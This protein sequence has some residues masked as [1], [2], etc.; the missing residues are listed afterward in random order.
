MMLTALVP[1][2]G[3]HTNGR[4]R[5]RLTRGRGHRNGRRLAN[6]CLTIFLLSLTFM[7][8]V[9]VALICTRPSSHPKVR[10]YFQNRC[11]T[12]TVGGK[13]WNSWSSRPLAE[14]CCDRSKRFRPRVLTAFLDRCLTGVKQSPWPNLTPEFAARSAADTSVGSVLRQFV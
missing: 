1:A 2:A 3:T 6:A 8:D 4:A 12:S 11:V 5:R 14:Y 9:I 13:E 7:P 10:L